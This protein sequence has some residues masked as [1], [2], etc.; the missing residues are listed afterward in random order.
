MLAK[1]IRIAGHSD[2]FRSGA[3]HGGMRYRLTRRQRMAQFGISQPMLRLEDPALLMGEGQFVDDLMPEG[4]AHAYVLRSPY[5]HADV[6]SV[7]AAAAR[8]MPG[9]LAVY[10]GADVSALGDIPT[11]AFPKMKEGTE[12]Q[13]HGQQVLARGRVRYRG[14]P[15]AFVVAESRDQAHDA[16]EAIDVE[17]SALPV[18]TDA[19]ACTLPGAPQIW[20]NAPGNVAF[21]FVLGDEQATN[22]GIANAAHVVKLDVINNRVVLNAIET[23]A[24]L[25]RFEGGRMILH[26]TT[27]MPHRLKEQLADT[28]FKLPREAVQVLVGDVG[29]GFGGKNGLYV[30][31]CMVLHAARDLG[32]PVKW[33]GDRDEAF[34]ADTHGRDNV[35]TG[36]LALDA[37]GMPLAFRVRNYANLGAYNANGSAV[38]PT[39]M[40]MAP[41][42]YRIPQVYVHVSGTFTNTMP[43]D[44]YRGAGRPEIT[45]LIERL[46]DQ[47]ARDL[48]EDPSLYR[49]RIALQPEVFP[50]TTPTGL[51][52]E[53][54]DF[55]ALLDQAKERVDWDGFSERRGESEAQGLLRGIGMCLYIERCGGGPALSEAAK[56]DVQADG[57][58]TVRIGSQSNGQAHWTSYAQIVHEWLGVDPE[59]VV[60]IQGDTD[61]VET[62]TGTGGSWSIPMGGGAIAR[63]ADKIIEKAKR[64]AAEKFEAAETDINFTDGVFSVTGT[65]LQMTL[66][67]VA[68]LA[69]DPANLAEGEEPGLGGFDR[70]V[71]ENHTFPYGVHI[72]EVEVDPDTGAFVLG[73]YTVVHDFGRALNPLLLEGQVHGGIAQGIGQALFERTVYDDEGQLLS[74]SYMDYHLPRATDFPNFDFVPVETPTVANPLGVK[75]CGEA[76]ATGAPP[77]V[78]NAMLDALSALGVEHIDMPT[79]PESI[80]RAIQAAEV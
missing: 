59:D 24:A 5:A 35:T 39:N 65:D 43:T 1:L 2:P 4:L 18:V 53:S 42:A 52:Y 30:E 37:N 63:A 44:A 49:A 26:A 10:T 72:A 47:A 6:T 56:V 29:G 8:A 34:L 55:G 23:R 41:N 71:P 7:D 12:Y 73:A 17:Y 19:K 22:A 51:T 33:I 74:G 21:D 50:Y 31:N 16:A 77:A 58:V 40:H 78:I 15:V 68:K 48:G 61:E 80:W 3:A 38:S 9:V 67:D 70:F 25:G 28:V 54:A 36:E 69:E 66:P 14:E 20:D 13:H 46:V 62:G 76:G 79:T 64:I 75:G 45:Y 27:Q 11:L 32:R 57:T 60:L